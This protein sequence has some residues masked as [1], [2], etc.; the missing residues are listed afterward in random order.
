MLAAEFTK[1]T[2]RRKPVLTFNRISDGRRAHVET[3]TVASKPEAR[4]LAAERNAVC[5]NF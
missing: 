1:G 2:K 5:W 4:R 3:L